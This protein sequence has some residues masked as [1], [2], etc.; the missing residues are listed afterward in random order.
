MLYL[1]GYIEK[2]GAWISFD[3]DLLSEMKKSKIECPEKIQG[4]QKLLELIESDV[5]IREYLENVVIKLFN[6]EK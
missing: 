5:T 4:D 6:E 1:W 3:E 2:K